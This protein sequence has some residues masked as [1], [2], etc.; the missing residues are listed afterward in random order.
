MKHLLS[1]QLLFISITI[2]K[3]HSKCT[4]QNCLTHDS[5]QTYCT[6]CSS[7]SYSLNTTTNTRYYRACSNSSKHYNS[8][9]SVSC[10][11]PCATSASSSY[12]VSC[13]SGY[14]MTGCGIYVQK[15]RLRTAQIQ[16]QTAQL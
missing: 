6:T 8:S 12:C 5:T 15:F 10:V 2:I 1:I 7:A 11:S 14:Q 4:I 16:L 13:I 9:S 3:V